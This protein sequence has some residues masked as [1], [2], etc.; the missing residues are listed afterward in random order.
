MPDCEHEQPVSNSNFY[1]CTISNYCSKYKSDNMK[2]RHSIEKTHSFWYWKV[3]SK[4]ILFVVQI[5]SIVPILHI[6]TTWLV[7]DP[8]DRL[9]FSN[10]DQFSNDSACI[11][12]LGFVPSLRIDETFFSFQNP[13]IFEHVALLRV[14]S[15]LFAH[16]KASCVTIWWKYVVLA[17][18]NQH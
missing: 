3:D 11:S 15:S 14:W 8:I 4:Q 2:G 5:F 7:F 16:K 10:S 18:S 17:F 9:H 1:R 13:C 6:F 12:S